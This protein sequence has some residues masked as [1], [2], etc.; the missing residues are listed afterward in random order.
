MKWLF[1]WITGK[2]KNR[3]LEIASPFSIEHYPETGRFYPKYKKCYIKRNYDTGIY[4]E[5]E[6]Y[7]MGLADYGVTVAE[8]DKI[9]TLF[10]EQRLKENVKVLKR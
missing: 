9:L 7:F 4:K 10:K 2:V 5:L 1:D 8:A 6:P 3:A